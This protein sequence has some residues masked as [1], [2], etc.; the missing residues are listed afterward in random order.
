MDPRRDR[1]GTAMRISL[2]L[3]ACAAPALVRAADDEYAIGRTR[4]GA[5][6]I[7]V[8]LDVQAANDLTPGE[9]RLVVFVRPGGT[10]DTMGLHPGDVLLTLNDA[11]IST[12]RDI[13][14]VVSSVQPGDAA[15][16]L[17]STAQGSAQ[18]DGTFQPRQPRPPGMPWFGGQ[19]GWGAGGAPAPPMSAQEQIEAVL[20]QQQALAD[21]RA[22]VAALR[23]AWMDDDADG[24]NG[25]PAG[26]RPPWRFIHDY[27]GPV[28]ANRVDL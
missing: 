4:L 17:V 25:T 18:R 5:F 7:P 24:G 21:A 11:P 12:W 20:L 27:D 26:E 2:I 3:L 28:I 13:R 10:A 16:A 6:T 15:H 19:P 8:P 23:E 1:D 9:G 22:A 14:D